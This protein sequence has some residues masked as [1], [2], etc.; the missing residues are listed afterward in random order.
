MDLDGKKRQTGCGTE[1][2]ALQV[3]NIIVAPDWRITGLTA[4][5]ISCEKLQKTNLC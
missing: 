3:S 2:W 5:L 4:T 1:S